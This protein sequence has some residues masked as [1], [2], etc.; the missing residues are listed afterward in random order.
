MIE[1][2]QMEEKDAAIQLHI[3]RVGEEEQRDRRP[4]GAAC[5]AALFILDG[6]GFLEHC[7]NLSVNCY[8]YIL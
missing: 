2:L 6:K 7:T 1:Q 3:Q 4:I 8:G 5:F